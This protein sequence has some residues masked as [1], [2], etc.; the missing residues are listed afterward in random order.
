MKKKI[1]VLLLFLFNISFFY[2]DSSSADYVG[3]DYEIDIVRCLAT[4]EYGVKMYGYKLYP[5]E[6]LKNNEKRLLE[7]AVD[8][9]RVEKGDVYF[10]DIIIDTPSQKLICLV[11]IDR[12]YNNGNNY[13]YTWWG[14]FKYYLNR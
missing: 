11:R 8:E 5:I 9:Y 6:N 10:V 4:Y 14:L 12:V 7:E 3:K 13:D 2:A 1:F